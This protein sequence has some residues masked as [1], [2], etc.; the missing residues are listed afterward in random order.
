MKSSRT[1]DSSLDAQ[2]DG[3]GVQFQRDDSQ[4]M[5]S[6]KRSNSS[7]SIKLNLLLGMTVGSSGWWTWAKK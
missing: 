6:L 3:C 1:L 5:M 2:E 7:K 4:T